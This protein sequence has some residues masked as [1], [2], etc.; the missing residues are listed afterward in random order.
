MILRT[1]AHG[2][3]SNATHLYPSFL[4]CF[5][6]SF[7]LLSPLHTYPPFFYSHTHPAICSFF[8]PFILS[9]PFSIQ[10]LPLLP[11]SVLP[12]SFPQPFT[13]QQPSVPH[14]SFLPDSLHQ[15]QHRDKASLCLSGSSLFSS[16]KD[17]HGHP[18]G[19]WVENMSPSTPQSTWGW[20]KPGER[21]QRRGLLTPGI[22]SLEIPLFQT[23]DAWTTNQES[24][25]ETKG[26]STTFNPSSHISAAFPKSPCSWGKKVHLHLLRIWTWTPPAPPL[27]L[28]PHSLDSL[29]TG[30]PPPCSDCC[31]TPFPV[32][33]LNRATAIKAG[34]RPQS[35]ELLVPELPLPDATSP[36]GKSPESPA[37][38]TRITMPLAM[39]DFSVS[40]P[41]MHPT[42]L[43]HAP[44]C[45][46]DQ[47]VSPPL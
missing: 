6:L 25:I 34:S 1:F 33:S 19:Q 24:K 12:L 40:S 8:L 43:P 17:T 27:E 13:A 28:G 22:S 14:P 18:A 11:S 30:Q 31:H 10:T 38:H 39:L 47:S 32:S 42:C 5:L 16:G 46:S 44:L 35:Y 4:P 36:T 37:W 23:W 9:L 2:L 21:G 20:Q 45:H 3:L 15:P 41:Y 7:L 26:E 29:R